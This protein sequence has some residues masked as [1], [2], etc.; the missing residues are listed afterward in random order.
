M[1]ALLCVKRT[2]TKRFNAAGAGYLHRWTDNKRKNMSRPKTKKRSEWAMDQI[3]VRPDQKKRFV[4]I[5]KKMRMAGNVVYASE[6]FEMMLD[7]F[8]IDC[9]KKGGVE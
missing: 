8:K 7:R 5:F 6:L 3:H 1:Q 2:P 9:S 4:E